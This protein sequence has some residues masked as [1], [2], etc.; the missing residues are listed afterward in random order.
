MKTGFDHILSPA[1]LNLFLHITGQRRDGY[2]LLQSL[3]VLIDWCDILHFELREDG[4]I[5][6][7]DLG[8]Q[9][10]EN[11]L[12][13]RAAKLLQQK[14]GTS[15]GIDI[16][17]EK[18]IP[19]QAGL[20]GGSSNAATVLLALNRLWGLHLPLTELHTLG[21]Q[22]GADVPFFLHNGPAWVEGIGEILSPISLPEEV[23][24]QTVAVV[25]PPIGVSTQQL[26]LNP[27]LTKNSK[28]VIIADFISDAFKKKYTDNCSG[29]VK[30]EFTVFDTVFGFG[31]NDL[32]T[33]AE[34]VEPEIK[35]AIDMLSKYAG[36]T[37]RMTGSGSAVFAPIR[38][39]RVGLP[40]QS[41]N[42]PLCE[43]WLL[44]KCR[45]LP[46]HPQAY[47]LTV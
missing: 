23:Y 34:Q 4:K 13:V 44:K 9:L 6:R 47:L 5:Q 26:F 28:P 45:I 20:G 42:I 22:L 16:S 18:H 7:H 40:E 46:A 2:H 30:G 41:T 3:M 15:L 17:V 27:L 43:G 29:S 1:K 39:D 37:A 14:T 19:T 12:I 11:D 35:K 8:E 21:I 36:T 10:P 25:K 38:N 32:Q 31:C 24:Q 33:V